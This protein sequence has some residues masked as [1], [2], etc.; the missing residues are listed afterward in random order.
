MAQ[1]QSL[2]QADVEA[3]KHHKK[4][5]EKKKL[6]KINDVMKME[7]D[8]IDD[9]NKFIKTL[10]TSLKKKHQAK[11][12]SIKHQGDIDEIVEG[13]KKSVKSEKKTQKELSKHL[14]KFGIKSNE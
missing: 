7:K 3:D 10:S 1:Q 13:K 4:D 2:T 12:N 11:I 14:N 5:S 9:D 8:S 6:E